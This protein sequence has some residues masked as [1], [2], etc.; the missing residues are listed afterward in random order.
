MRFLALFI[1]KS[2]E[3]TVEENIRKKTIVSFLVFFIMTIVVISGWIY[4]KRQPLDHGSIGGVQL[5]FR[6]VLDANERIFDNGF[7][8]NHLAKTYPKSAAA[9]KVRVNGDLG[10]SKDFNAASWKLQVVKSAGDTL[11]VTLDDIKKLPK[12]EIIFDFKCIEGW[13]Q[14]T[15]WGGVKF[16]DFMK[17]FHLNE[18][19]AMKYIGMSTPD[20]KYYVGIDMPSALHPQTLFCYEMNGKPLPLNQGFPL[21]MIIP[22]KYGI[23]SLKRIGTLFFSEERPR[24]FW[25]E[26]GYDYYSGL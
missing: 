1:T 16:S 20:E 4:L 22:V 23:K 10:L 7:S 24:D 8:Y 18:Q 26:R 6:K 12:T 5:P 11:Y 2:S 9:K 14:V 25:F 13:S 21:R 15:H 3:L 19:A 17:A